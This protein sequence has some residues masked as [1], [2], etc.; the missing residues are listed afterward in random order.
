M[1]ADLIRVLAA[2]AALLAPWGLAQAQDVQFANERVA[3]PGGDEVQLVSS[4]EGT[5][6]APCDSCQGSCNNGCGGRWFGDVEATFLRYHRN[7]N[8]NTND[9]FNFAFAPRITVGYMNDDGFGIRMRYWGYNHTGTGNFNGVDPTDINVNTY[10]IDAEL[11]QNV[12][13]TEFTSVEFSGGIRYNDFN[14]TVSQ[15]GAQTQADSFSAVGLIFGL[16]ARRTMFNGN[17]YARWNTSLLPSD[18]NA[19]GGHGKEFDQMLTQTEV[20]VGYEQ[21][22]TLSNGSVA[23][24]RAGLECSYW[25]D[26]VHDA[27]DPNDNTSI[28][29]AGA[30]LGVGLLY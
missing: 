18:H 17:V 8:L 16:K 2:V 21:F 26:Y 6:L 27:A 3:K 25:T 7:D 4:M 11:F 10:N 19:I 14:E 29:F 22:T 30:V 1:K 15:G 28:G 5:S 13:L 23:W 12:Q 20:G 9:I 24:W